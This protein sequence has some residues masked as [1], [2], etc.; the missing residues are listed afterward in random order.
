MLPPDRSFQSKRGPAFAL[1]AITF[2]QNQ[3]MAKSIKESAKKRIQ[4]DADVEMADATKPGPSIQSM[5]DKAVS[6]RFKKS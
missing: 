1:R 5:I 6:A 2:T 4:K 3:E